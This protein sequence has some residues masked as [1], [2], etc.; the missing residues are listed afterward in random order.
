MFIASLT[1]PPNPPSMIII[2]H[3]IDPVIKSALKYS[4][5]PHLLVPTCH[6]PGGVEV[7]VKVTPLVADLERSCK[8]G[9]F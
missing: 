3:V 6:E 5:A 2:S 1:P 4:T 8:V 7:D 9:A